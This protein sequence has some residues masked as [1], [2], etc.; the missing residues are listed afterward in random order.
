MPGVLPIFSS[1]TEPRGEFCGYRRGIQETDGKV[2]R[3]E[4]MQWYVLQAAAQWSGATASRN[5]VRDELRK[6][7]QTRLFETYMTMCH[8]LFDRREETL[9]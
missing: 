2:S 5:C 8:T 1:V 7:A 9:C 3:L 4:E 6:T